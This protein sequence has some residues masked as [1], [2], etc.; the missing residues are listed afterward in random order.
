MPAAVTEKRALPLAPPPPPL[1]ANGKALYCR[2]WRGQRLG[3]V[4]SLGKRREVRTVLWTASWRLWVG[5]LRVAAGRWVRRH[6]RVAPARPGVRGWVGF[7][8]EPSLL[9]PLA[10]LP[11]ARF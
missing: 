9:C 7:A 10:E 6:F 2:V 8:G 5:S 11:E 4:A 1:A 3:Q